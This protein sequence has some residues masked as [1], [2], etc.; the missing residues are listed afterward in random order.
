MCVLTQML[1]FLKGKVYA[2]SNLGLSFFIKK[3]KK[4]NT[5]AESYN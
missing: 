1:L 2:Q 3:L 5:Y 4:R